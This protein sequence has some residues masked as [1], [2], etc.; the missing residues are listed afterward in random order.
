MHVK[1]IAQL[2][3]FLKALPF[4]LLAPIKVAF[5]VLSVL[6]AL[7]YTPDIGAE[8]LLVQVWALKVLGSS[9]SDVSLPLEPAKYSNPCSCATHRLSPR[10]KAHRRL[11][12]PRLLH[13][14]TSHR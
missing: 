2:P 11:A 8:Y 7:W 9:F 1:Y 10:R 13:S 12:Q 4:L 6:H 3:S 14:R 5:Q